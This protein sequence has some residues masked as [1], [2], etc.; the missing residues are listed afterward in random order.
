MQITLPPKRDGTLPKESEI[1]LIKRYLELGEEMRYLLGQSV[2]IEEDILRIKSQKRPRCNK[3]NVPPAINPIYCAIFKI[4]QR[5][6]IAIWSILDDAIC[7][8]FRDYSHVLVDGKP[9]DLLHVVSMFNHYTTIHEYLH[10]S[11]G[12]HLTY[13]DFSLIQEI[14]NRLSRWVD[15]VDEMYNTSKKSYNPSKAKY[16]KKCVKKYKKCIANV[17]EIANTDS[18]IL[19]S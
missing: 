4:N 18:N 12:E 8:D 19:P 13:E 5:S 2:V 16:T 17:L 15:D 10:L 1:T 3:Y 6:K 7:A 14:M 11:K 9:S